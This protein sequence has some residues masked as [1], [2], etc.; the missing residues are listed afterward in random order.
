MISFQ[1]GKVK[2]LSLLGIKIAVKE[3]DSKEIESLEES[4]RSEEFK[5][6]MFKFYG[7][8]GLGGEEEE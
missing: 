5:E 1:K 7:A 6:R 2:I 4:W 3:L 8:D